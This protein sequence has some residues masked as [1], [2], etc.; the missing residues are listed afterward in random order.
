MD[1]PVAFNGLGGWVAGGAIFGILAAFWSSLKGFLWRIINVFICRATI[2]SSFSLQERVMIRLALGRGWKL[3]PFRDRGF[4]FE[5]GWSPKDDRAILHVGEYLYWGTFIYRRGWSFL[6]VSRPL[7]S[8]SPP[9]ATTRGAA[10]PGELQA[11]SNDKGMTIYWIRGTVNIE[12]LMAESADMHNEVSASDRKFVVVKWPVG[13]RETHDEASIYWPEKY[14]RFCRDEERTWHPPNRQVRLEDMWLSPEAERFVLDAERWIDAKQWY[15][16]RSIPWRMGALLCGI[17]GSG[18]TS[19]V[20]ALGFRHKLPVF[21]LQLSLIGNDDLFKYFTKAS[22]CAPCIL[23]IEDVDGVFHGRKN[24][25][26]EEN[27]AEYHMMRRMA[28]M[29]RPRTASAQ[30]DIFGREDEPE[31]LF[32]PPLS[33]DTLLNCIDGVDSSEGIL[34]VMTTNDITKVDQALGRPVEGEE[35]LSTRPGRLDRVVRFGYLGPEGYRKISS[36][37]LKGFPDLEQALL[38]REE[39]HPRDLAPAQ[40]QEICRAAALTAKFDGELIAIRAVDKVISTMDG[41]KN[42]SVSRGSQSREG[43]RADPSFAGA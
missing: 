22:E 29:S 31:P 6:L 36:R 28:A 25:L 21:S 11:A 14:Y 10:A 27:P 37:I 8:E 33:F 32:K 39:L 16:E 5:N 42:G 23:L 4:M 17:P 43:V 24:V 41:E 20:R 2:P 19:I 1:G 34:L 9:A 15:R 12:E 26:A 35:S 40:W 38:A 18:K 7:Q 30:G 13:K 3:L